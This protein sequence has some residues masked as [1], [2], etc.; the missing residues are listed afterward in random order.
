MEATINV[1]NSLAVGTAFV[2]RTEDEEE[3]HT[4]A[5][6]E[7][8]PFDLELQVEVQKAFI[9]GSSALIDNPFMC[10]LFVGKLDG[11]GFIPRNCR[12]KGGRSSLDDMMMKL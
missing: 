8:D 12:Q 2:P 4:E 1:A 6:N 5:R 9:K 10:G 7:N 3:Q 11:S